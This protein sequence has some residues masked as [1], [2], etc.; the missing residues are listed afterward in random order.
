MNQ[1]AGNCLQGGL[2]GLGYGYG[3]REPDPPTTAE[4]LK[5]RAAARIMEIEAELAAA[6]GKRAELEKLRKIVAAMEST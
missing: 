6:D 5:A 2:Q 1:A 4:G 3:Y